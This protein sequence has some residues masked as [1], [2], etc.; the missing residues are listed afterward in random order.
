MKRLSLIAM[1]VMLASCQESGAPS[2]QGDLAVGKLGVPQQSEALDAKPK[3]ALPEDCIAY[4]PGKNGKPDVCTWMAKRLT[5]QEK[6][7][8]EASGGRVLSGI[9]DPSE[10]CAIPADDTGKS[11]NKSTDCEI[12]CDASEHKCRAYSNLGMTLDEFGTVIETEE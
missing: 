5:S 3:Q 10:Y 8:C 4:Q 7:K 9:L 2:M 1:M 6:R 11:C 12:G